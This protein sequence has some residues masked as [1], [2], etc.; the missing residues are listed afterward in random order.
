MDSNLWDRVKEIFNNAISLDE[1]KR[2]DYINV[3][4]GEN[5]KLKLEV[6]SLINSYGVS[7]EFLDNP[8]KDLNFSTQSEKDLYINKIIGAYKISSLIAEGGMG[9]VYLGIRSDNEF[10]QK[11][12]IKLIK[13][14][15]QSNYLL[16]RFQNE[17]QTLA[18]L[19]HPFIANLLDGGTTDDGVPYFIM[20]YIDGKPLTDYCDE[21]RLTIDERLLLFQKICS[22][23]NYAHKNLVV[24]RDL[25]PSNILITKDGNPKLLDFGI[26]KILKDDS[27][28]NISDQ[29]VTKVWNF[30]P[31]YASPEQIKGEKITTSTDI[32]SLGVVLYKLL[33]GYRPYN[34]KSYLPAEITRIVCDTNTEKPSTIVRS[35]LKRELSAKEEEPPSP[36]DIGKARGDTVEKISKKLSGDLDNIVLMAMRKDSDRRY[37]SVEQFSEDIRRHLEGLPIIARKNSVRYK[38]IKFFERHRAGVITAFIFLLI[39]IAGI[40]GIVIQ[41]NAAS[42]ERDRAILE[43]KKSERINTFLQDILAAPNPQVD[44]KDVKVIDVL[45][46]ASKKIN[47][48]LS[49]D[50]EIKAAALYTIGT[51]YMGLGLYNDAEKYLKNSLIISEKIFSANDPQIAKVMVQLGADYQNKSDY[52]K[53][54]SLYKKALRIYMLKGGKIS[55]GEATALSDYGSSLHYQGKYD[56]AKKYQTKALDAYRKIYGNNDPHVINSLNDL[57]TI[58]GDA[59]DWNSAAK[60]AKEVLDL[61]LK[62][63][64]KESVNYSLALSNYASTLEVQGKLDEAIKYQREAVEIKKK[65]QGENHP[66]AMFAQITLADELMKRGDNAEAAKLSKEAMESLDKSLPHINA[67]TAYSRVVYANA[68]IKLKD[69]KKA[70]PFINDALKIREKLYSPNHYLITATKV[71]LGTCL[72]GLKQYIRAEQ[73]LKNCY[74]KIDKN[75]EGKKYIR[76]ITLQNLV[77]VYKA[78]GNKKA[79]K[80]YEADLDKE[81]Q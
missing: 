4:C 7:G 40:T 75:D 46:N 6:K 48:E 39:I 34:L 55:S 53:A 45:K 37:S 52:T 67:L 79:E 21:N 81:K 8:E 73:I 54:D 44:G 62:S 13:H 9:R 24:H 22:A 64:G 15:S 5:E 35:T 69:F 49:D 72:A 56:E 28:T 18:N 60:Y 77:K 63:N 3:A 11:A 19:N 76:I 50:P 31:D 65:V 71:L 70:L 36:A 41:S 27:T 17:R 33:T 43:A 57:G 61:S 78:T 30:T 2:E 1:N 80:Q 29:T 59:G 47:K 51:T 26:A 42:N 25:K 38:S 68:L 20:E 12:A 10:S 16:Q 66:D 32:Y 23:V 14:E 58:A 74:S